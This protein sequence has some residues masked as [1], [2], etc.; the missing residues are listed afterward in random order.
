MAILVK[1]FEN[2]DFDQNFRNISISVKNFQ[3]N[4][5]FGENFRKISILAKMFET[6][7]F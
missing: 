5:Y 7:R 1:I 2:L 4:P 6:S 3:K